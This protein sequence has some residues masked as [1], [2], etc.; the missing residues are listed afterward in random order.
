MQKLSVLFE[1]SDLI[2]VDKPAGLLVIPDQHTKEPQTLSGA[3]S[4]HLNSKA[5]V[6]HRIDRDTSGVV[7]FA[8]NP[9]AHKALCAQ[10]EASSVSK[11]YLA[12]LNGNPADDEGFIDKPIA[13][14][15]REVSISEDGKPSRTD[16]TVL[17]RFRDYS[18][19]EARPRT[20]RR[21]QIRIHFWALGHSL[22]VDPQYFSQSELLLSSFKKKYKAGPAVEKPLIARLTLHA[23]SV[24]FDNPSDGARI[25][26]EAPVPDDFNLALKMLRK[27][28]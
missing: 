8:R 15:G 6:V 4:Q 27:Y 9:Q 28:N 7:I 3:V 26:V 19:V 23:K 17:E 11:T 25:T 14:D 2:A 13:V 5:W 22:A 1:N 16:Y 12:I 20:G 10:F 18:L 24:S 21:H